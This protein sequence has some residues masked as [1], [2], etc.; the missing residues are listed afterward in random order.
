MSTTRSWQPCATVSQLRTAVKLEPRPEPGPQPESGSSSGTAAV[1][2]QDRRRASSPPADR[3]PARRGGEVRCRVAVSSRRA[4]RRVE[5]ATAPDG[6]GVSEHAPRLPST[7][8][9][10]MSLVEAGWDSRGGPSTARAAHHRRRPSRRRPARSRRCI[11]VRCCPRTNAATYLCDATCEVWFERHGQ[12][13]GAGRATRQINRRLR[14]ALEHRDRSLRGSRLW[15]HPRSARPPHPALGRRRPHR[16]SQ[17]RAGMSRTITGCIIGASSPSPEPPMTISRHRQR[18]STAAA[19]DRLARPPTK[20]APAVAPVPGPPASAP[21]GGGTSPSSRN[22]HRRLAADRS[23]GRRADE[24]G[25]LRQHAGGVDRWQRL[26]S[27]LTR[28]EFGRIDQH[29]ERAFGDVEPDLVAVT[30][31]RDRSAVDRLGCDVPDAESG[32]AAGEPS[33][34]HQQHVLAETRRP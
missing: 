33:V 13:I 4:G 23:I 32:G 3:A 18:R 28:V 25:V 24:L 12:V 10:F 9:A 11:W 27:G 17:P 29:V 2:H 16:A 8:D 1:D 6:G 31:E 34:G 21:T 22:H 19:R 20:P 5:G 14:R 7:V 15:S 26:E 30:Q